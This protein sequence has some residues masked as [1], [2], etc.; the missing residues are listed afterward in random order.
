[1]EKKTYRQNYE[2]LREMFLE[3][4]ILG[5]CYTIN[6]TV[7]WMRPL[8][9]MWPE[10]LKINKETEA[11]RFSYQPGGIRD[12]QSNPRFTIQRIWRL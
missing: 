4:L 8:A 11:M 7:D 6:R 3:Q 10:G 2:M 9:K 5:I 1:M 12:E